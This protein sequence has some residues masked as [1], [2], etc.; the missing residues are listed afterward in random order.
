MIYTVTLNPAFDY[1]IVAENLNEGMTNR[2][3]YEQI[4]PEGKG[5]NV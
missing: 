5:L 3:S 1:A 2:A 4:L